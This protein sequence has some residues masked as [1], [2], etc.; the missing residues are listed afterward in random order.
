[1][2]KRGFTLI[3]LLVVIAIIAILAAILFPVFAKAR[4]S[5]RNASC[6]S[7]L[8]QI[9]TA[10][11]MYQQD[12]DNIMVSS[13]GGDLYRHNGN[14]VYYSFFIAPYTKNLGVL[15]CP[16]LTQPA[17]TVLDNPRLHGYGHQ[18]NNIGWGL[19]AANEADVKSPAETIYYSDYGRHNSWAE[20]IAEPD[21]ERF[22]PPSS[23]CPD[24]TRRYDQCTACPSGGSCCGDANTVVNRHNGTCNIAF[25]DGHVKAYKVSQVTGPFRT[26]ALRGGP[27]DMW[28]RN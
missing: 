22:Q 20:F 7:N 2:R 13:Y 26:A 8:K 14:V 12:Y 23:G 25:A 6:K 3:E 1:M 16:S 28:D 21:N 9:V 27:T 24:C 4:E 18:H 10:S 11:M 5:A 19:P 17:E 15:R